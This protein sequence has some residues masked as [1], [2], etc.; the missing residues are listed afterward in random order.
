M[1]KVNYYSLEYESR[2]IEPRIFANKEEA[3]AA[4]R[5]E[6]S[7]EAPEWMDGSDWMVLRKVTVEAAT[8]KAAILVVAEGRCTELE[9]VAEYRNRRTDYADEPVEHL[10]Y[11]RRYSG[12]TPGRLLLLP[13]E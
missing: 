5:E 6:A 10:Q 12:D 9:T 8:P 1:F 13:S 11:F 2:D 7:I 4:L 3:L